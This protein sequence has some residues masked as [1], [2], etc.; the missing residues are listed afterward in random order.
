MWCGAATDW[1]EY[2]K[3]DRVPCML[4]SLVIEH[5]DEKQ[6]QHQSVDVASD[7]DRK[8]DLFFA[9]VKSKSPNLL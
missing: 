3:S 6:I 4:S 1:L 9:T 2:Q 7:S 5:L 8:Q